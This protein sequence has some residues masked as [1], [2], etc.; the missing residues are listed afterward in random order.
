MKMKRLLD[1]FSISGHIPDGRFTLVLFVFVLLF[2][3][4]GSLL[5]HDPI[6]NP[7]K[8]ERNRP[9]DPNQPCSVGLVRQCNVFGSGKLKSR[10][11]SH[12]NCKCVSWTLNL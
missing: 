9:S 1:V 7:S 11:G 6:L 4:C 12:Y 8:Y 2:S 5:S 10:N 3:G